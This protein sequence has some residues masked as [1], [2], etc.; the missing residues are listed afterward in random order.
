MRPQPMTSVCAGDP[1]RTPTMAP[2][3][4]RMPTPQVPTRTPTIA[5]VPTAYK[6]DFVDNTP[7]RPLLW[8][9]L[10]LIFFLYVTFREFWVVHLKST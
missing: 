7:T 9:Q 1:P 2:V 4:T 6:V 3:T 8:P 5:P 10:I